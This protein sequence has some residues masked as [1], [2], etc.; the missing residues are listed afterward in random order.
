MQN[1]NY[2]SLCGKYKSEFKKKKKAQN[3]VKSSVSPLCEENIWGQFLQVGSSVGKAY[4]ASKIVKQTNKKKI[5]GKCRL[6]K[7]FVRVVF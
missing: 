5:L 3:N 6:E 7:L 4:N 1:R 2:Q